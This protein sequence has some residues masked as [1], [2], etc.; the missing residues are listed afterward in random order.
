[1]NNPLQSKQQER[2]LE[3]FGNTLD[4][5]DGW[6]IPDTTE[7]CD[8]K[9]TSWAEVNHVVQGLISDAARAAEEDTLRRVR[10]V[11]EKIADDNDD[12]MWAGREITDH[13]LAAL[14]ELSERKV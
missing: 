3:R 9:E 5:Q 10:S 4:N 1:M 14:E 7:H 8:S 11:I 2:F 13:I 12:G 6:W